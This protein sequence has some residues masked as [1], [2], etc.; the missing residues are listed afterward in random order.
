MSR[1]EAEQP[2]GA[3]TVRFEGG[4][5]VVVG[6]YRV[7]TVEKHA[8][9]LINCALGGV[10][11][12]IGVEGARQMLENMLKKWHLYENLFQGLGSPMENTADPPRIVV[13]R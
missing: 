4:V 1:P 11:E 2:Q 9:M 5:P 8:Q 3:V 6:P 7:M 12:T 13:P 10:V